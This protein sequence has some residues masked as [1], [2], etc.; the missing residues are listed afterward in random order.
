[1]DVTMSDSWVLFLVNKL[2]GTYSNIQHYFIL[3]LFKKKN[4]LC[5]NV[6]FV[7]EAVSVSQ[8]SYV[9]TDSVSHLCGKQNKCISDTCK[10]VNR[11]HPSDSAEVFSVSQR[12]V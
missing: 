4:K 5:V 6:C 2:I 8:C 11:T 9:D 7:N 10:K 3:I 1:M 12:N